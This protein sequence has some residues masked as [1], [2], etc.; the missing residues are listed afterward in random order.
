MTYKFFIT[1]N[2]EEGHTHNENSYGYATGANQKD[3]L[4]KQ[5]QT[6]YPLS[7]ICVYNLQEMQ[8]VQGSPS[9]AKYQVK[10]N[11]EIIPL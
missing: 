7:T 3:S 6:R 1:V 5:I 11:G 4:V 9:Y 10:D 2:P 8:R